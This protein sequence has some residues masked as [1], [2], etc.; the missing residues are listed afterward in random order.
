MHLQGTASTLGKF[1]LLVGALAAI[2]TTYALIA[3]RRNG[4]TESVPV[5]YDGWDDLM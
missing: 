2:M 4:S 3:K 5:E 1:A